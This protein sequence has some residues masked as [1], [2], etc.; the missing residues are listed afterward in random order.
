M[1]LHR[2]RFKAMGC[3]CA[4]QIHAGSASDARAWAASARG[5]IA[6]LERKYSRYRGDS[7]LS[8]IN[9][10][11]GDPR[12]VEVDPETASLFDYAAKCHAHSGGLFDITSGILRRAW[13]FRSGRL[14]EP[15]RIA[16]LLPNVG[17]EK[18]RWSGAHVALPRAG[19][20]LDLGGYVKEY[21]A[22]RVAGLLRAA[23]CRSGLVDL[24]GDLAIV[25]PHPDGAPWIVGIRDAAHPDRPAASVPVSAG[26]VATSGDYER[27]MVVDGVRYG[28]ILDPRTGW[29]VEGLASVTIF[30]P[31]CLVAGSV[32]TIALLQGEGARA[33]LDALGLPHARQAHGGE[34]ECR[35]PASAGPASAPTA[36]RGPRAAT[37]RRAR[38]RGGRRGRATRGAGSPLE[39]RPG[40]G[41][42]ASARS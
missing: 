23:G 24:G 3:P 29:P 32:S 38:A 33:W 19:M 21:A 27:C 28:H 20:E 36:A 2:F 35:F 25:G 41:G 14:P 37:P 10:S 7:L 42:S 5:E 11:A 13:D 16:E 8:R 40:G 22:D 6:R 31:T 4:L 9:A 18:V 17:W 26:G 1:G 30:A 34:L 15:A 12:G 39:R